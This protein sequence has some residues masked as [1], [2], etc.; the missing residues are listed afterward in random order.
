M[1]IGFIKQETLNI[2]ESRGVKAKVVKWLECQFRIAGIRPFSAKMTP[3][4]RKEK[5]NQPDFII[6]LRANINKGD[7]FRD[8]AIGSLWLGEKVID[9]VLK[10]FMTGTLEVAFTKVSIAVWKAEP[11]FD[12]EV[13]NY[14]YDIKTM[15][16]N[17]NNDQ[18]QA[19]QDDYNNY[20][21][22]PQSYQA[23]QQQQ[24]QQ[25][26]TQIDDDGDEIPF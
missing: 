9:G 23:P 19:Y 12:G 15:Q 10:K 2:K 17:Q 6:Y 7:T 16:D 1:Q 20:T 3:N 24:S 22:E 8:I 13:V 4:K 18:Q 26:Q 5:P 21:Q 25:S 14:L 11:R